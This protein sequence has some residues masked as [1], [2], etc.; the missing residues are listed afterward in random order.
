MRHIHMCTQDGLGRQDRN[1]S[2]EFIQTLLE[3]AVCTMF[4]FQ[5]SILTK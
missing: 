3:T 1:L 4:T 2:I 5:K